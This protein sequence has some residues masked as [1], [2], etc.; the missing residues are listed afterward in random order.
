[1]P[2]LTGNMQNDGTLFA[3]GETSLTAFLQSSSFLKVEANITSD[4]LRSLY[5]GQNDSV[6]LAD[7][8][9]DVTFLW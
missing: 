3:A 4:V 1:M 8:F 9:R 5:P 2:L 7:I 6:V